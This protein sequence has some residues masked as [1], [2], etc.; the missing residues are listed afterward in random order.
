M[1]NSGQKLRVRDVGG[2]RPVSVGFL[3]KE[4]KQIG[5]I[6]REIPQCD[7]E[8]ELIPLQIE[9]TSLFWHLPMRRP[10]PHART[11]QP[12]LDTPFQTR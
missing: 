9:A 11:L 1:V 8:G 10:L 4:K 3:Q 5:H 6:S 2:F 7:S 12:A